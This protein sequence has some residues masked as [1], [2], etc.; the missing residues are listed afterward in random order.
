MR[1]SRTV[2]VPCSDPPPPAPPALPPAEPSDDRTDKTRLG[3]TRTTLTPELRE[4]YKV[5]ETI[6]GVLV[7]EVDV[8]SEAA[9]RGD[10]ILQTNQGVVSARA[11]VLRNIDLAAADAE[12]PSSC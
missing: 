11:D 12:K 2:R 8:S 10:V 1:S 3:L 9:R 5:A 7:T 6:N 4:T